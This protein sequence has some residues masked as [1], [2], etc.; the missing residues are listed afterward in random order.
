MGDTMISSKA[1]TMRPVAETLTSM[2]PRSTSEMTSALRSSAGII[3]EPSQAPMASTAMATATA[4]A[5]RLSFRLR[6][7]L[8]GMA[9]SMV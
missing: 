7:S 6:C 9:L 4:T 3:S 1:G 2:V 8:T 5:A